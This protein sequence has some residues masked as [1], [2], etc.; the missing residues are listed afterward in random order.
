MRPLT[1]FA[2][3]A[4]TAAL[5]AGCGGSS[6]TGSTTTVP[7]A[8]L[9]STS[10]ASCGP[11][12]GP[13]VSDI[14]IRAFDLNCSQARSVILDYIGRGRA[15]AGW[16]CTPA[17]LSRKGTFG[18]CQAINGQGFASARWKLTSSTH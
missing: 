15:P 5:L 4:G 10:S 9:G 12:G 8:R 14:M 3:I 6:S 16:Q 7:T 11:F 17:A 13:G 18:D 1:A 2:A